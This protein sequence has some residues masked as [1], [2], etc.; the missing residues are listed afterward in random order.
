MFPVYKQLRIGCSQSGKVYY[1]CGRP[2]DMKKS[3]REIE[4]NRSE[5]PSKDTLAIVV[6]EGC[7]RVS[8]VFNN[9]KVVDYEGSGDES[10][11]ARS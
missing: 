2:T 8:F 9:G 3:L 11:F 5:M 4:L 10:S 6:N 7:R 1:G